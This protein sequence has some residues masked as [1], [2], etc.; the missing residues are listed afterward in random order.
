MPDLNRVI[1]RVKALLAVSKSD[2]EHE[3]ALAAERAAELMATYR[4]EEA[5]L[6]VDDTSRAAEDIKERVLLDNTT[7]K[8]VAW[9]ELIADGVAKSLGCHLYLTGEG[10]A[11]FGREGATQAWRYTC[12]Y[13][14][15]EVNRLADEAWEAEAFEATLAGHT[16]KKWKNSFR[17]GCAQSIIMRLYETAKPKPASSNEQALMIIDKDDME[18]ESQYN[19]MAEGFTKADAIGYISN[20]TGYK[21]GLDAGQDLPLGGGR[22]GLPEGQRSLS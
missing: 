15:N 22:A 13:L 8:R 17:V 7:K 10:P 19:I 11:V 12:Q 21:A 20:R 6:R 3:A 2:N 5:Q 14:F 18:L 9:K 1:E 16:I 4:L